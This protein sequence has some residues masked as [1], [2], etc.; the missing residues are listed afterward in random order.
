MG[1]TPA[2]V[3]SP[4]WVDATDD[5]IA[6]FGDYAC[7]SL[8]VFDADASAVSKLEATFGALTNLTCVSGRVAFIGEAMTEREA[9]AKAAAAGF[10]LAA[11]IRVL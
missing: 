6:D 1:N 8:W 4:V 10:A 3:K 7:R 11:R 5:E 2:N 9:E